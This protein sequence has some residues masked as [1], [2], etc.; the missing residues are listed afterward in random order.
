MSSDS[1]SFH[2]PRINERS[3]K[4]K[5]N[6]ELLLNYTQSSID[7]MP[8]QIQKLNKQLLSIQLV[9]YSYDKAPT[10]QNL[11]YSKAEM[12]GFWMFLCSKSGHV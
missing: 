8:R 6:S 1:S 11:N 10:I 12:S 2:N 7:R 5:I 3:F 9:T 4:K